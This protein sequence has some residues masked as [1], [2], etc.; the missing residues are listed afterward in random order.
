VFLAAAAAVC[1]C[2]ETIK[3]FIHNGVLITSHIPYAN[4]S[5]VE[6]EEHEVYAH[7]STSASLLVTGTFSPADRTQN[8]KAACL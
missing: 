8:G 2:T 4:G 3:E 5:D 6:D 7:G 1:V